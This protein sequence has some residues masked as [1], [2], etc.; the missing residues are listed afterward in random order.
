[1]FGLPWGIVLPTLVGSLIVGALCGAVGT[2]VVRLKLSSLGFAMAHAAFAG[3]AFGGMIGGI[4]P[5]WT[6]LAFSLSAAGALGP[7]ADAARMHIDTV[8]GAVF[9]ITMALGL[10]FVH[11]TASAGIG[12]GA[13]SLLWGSVLGLDW[14]DVAVL[15]AAAA[16]FLVMVV[17]W[18]RGF[19][20]L[21]LDRKLALS[22]G[23][24]AGAY[25]Y[26][27]LFASAIIVAVSLRI[28]GGLLIYSL[29]VLPASAAL[30][31]VYDARKAFFVAPLLGMVGAV[32]GLLLS[33]WADLPI[34]GSIALCAAG[35]FL[36]S[37]LL[38]PKRRRARLLRDGPAGRLDSD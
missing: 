11:R 37:V 7:L 35:L 30:Q 22:S 12:S 24:P 2:F 20:A 14:P 34:G 16:A 3:A 15:G 8:L 28:A 31:W 23:L 38:S 33:L 5:T 6:A 1:V 26:A 25:F 27:I 10:I 36:A 17:G 29:T 21:L 4:D 18:G 32:G 9:P 19:V 13:L